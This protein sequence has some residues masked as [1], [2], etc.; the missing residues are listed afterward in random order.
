MNSIDIFRGND[1]LFSLQ[2]SVVP[3]V[4]E[5]IWFDCSVDKSV[6][7]KVT[8]RSFDLDKVKGLFKINLFVERIW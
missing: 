2:S 7:Y 5:W 4:G 8:S 6:C 1:I 3:E